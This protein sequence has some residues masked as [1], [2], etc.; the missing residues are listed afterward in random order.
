MGN[1]VNISR[2]TAVTHMDSN[3]DDTLLGYI[4]ALMMVTITEISM[5]VSPLLWRRA[6]DGIQIE[7]IAS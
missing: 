2:E 5:Y 1:I 4:P 6:D 7:D 3:N